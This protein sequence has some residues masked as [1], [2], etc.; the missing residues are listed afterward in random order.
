MA[1]NIIDGFY[2]GNSLPIDNR[3]VKDNQTERQNIQY[4]YDGLKVFQLDNRKTY[5][6]NDSTSSWDEDSSS[7]GFNGEGQDNYLTQFNGTQSLTASTIYNNSGNYGI[8]TSQSKTQ[9]QI[10]GDNQPINISNTNDY[11]GFSYNYYNQ[12]S[13]SIFDFSKGSVKMEFSNTGEFGILSRT[14]SSATSS[15]GN[16]IKIN[17]SGYNIFKSDNTNY[18]NKLTVDSSST[19]FNSAQNIYFGE[20][21]RFNNTIYDKIT[22]I[23]YSGAN[24][25]TIT[26]SYKT[27]G[28]I[29]TVS[30]IYSS[31]STLNLNFGNGLISNN[32]IFNTA[33]NTDAFLMLPSYSGNSNEIGR[34][35][36]INLQSF[37]GNGITSV[38]SGNLIIDSSMNILKKNG[39][40]T[41]LGPLTLSIGQTIKLTTII[42]GSNYYWKVIDIN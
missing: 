6:W 28:S 22:Y 13:E 34:T 26:N 25:F 42:I 11:T 5:I 3:I 38:A 16:Y 41:D 14:N 40:G 36:T 17:K 23:D 18:F 2:L 8:G 20:E 12:G 19:E 7:S 24:T 15:F 4:K 1:I 33:K 9:L 21:V 37:L 30:S 32:I 10:N 39:Q 29:N 31:S 27:N 35:L